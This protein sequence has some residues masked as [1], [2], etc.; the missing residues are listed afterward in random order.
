[1][2]FVA[3][4]HVHSKYSRAVSQDMIL[5]IMTKFALK[6][7]IDIL[8]TADWTHPLW[9]REIKS[10]LEES[11]SGL[12]K[13]KN[14]KSETLFILSTE[15]S[16]IYSQGGRVRRI[17]NL[18][19]SKSFET[20]EK[21]SQEL[22]KRGCNLHSDGRPIIGLSSK[23]L[24][25]L[26]LSID[27]KVLFIPAHVWT[28]WF[29][30]YGSNSGFDSLEECFGELSKYIYAVETGL[31]S[32]PSMN[33]R[34]K[35][36]ENRSIISSSDSHSPA[37]MGREATV[38]LNKNGMSNDKSQSRSN[39]DQMSNQQISFDDIAK[40]IKRDPSGKLKI[41]YTI[42]FY[43]EE[44][45]YH[46]TGHRNCKL[47]QSPLETKE[48]GVLCPVCHKPLTLGVM[49]RVEQLAKTQDNIEIKSN[50]FGVKWIGDPN[51]IHPPFVRLVP[52]LEILAE[53]LSSTVFSQKTK[54]CFDNLCQRFGSEVNVLLKTKIED[55]D[56]E[57]GEKIA[58]GIAKV[59][60]GDIVIRPGYDGE[61]GKVGIWDKEN[62]KGVSVSK[63]SSEQKKQLGLF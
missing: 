17:H 48:K 12:F 1:M 31:S 16:S 54:E 25:E 6:K 9:F 61:Y 52:L 34:I 35:E 62:E 13:I 50:Q 41:G 44:G 55:I 49:H 27:E 43:P 5:P 28:P 8:A 4:L 59:R 15:I 7:G 24:L 36:L 10:Q 3:D 45:K 60:S 42:E 23:D 19:F 14:P 38:F 21:I 56:K 57:F 33:W 37:K 22:N 18:V 29:A 26:V 53:S 63:K 39:R 58:E 11:N 20:C 47:L 51:R 46:Y 32:D 40:A 2:Q 30:L